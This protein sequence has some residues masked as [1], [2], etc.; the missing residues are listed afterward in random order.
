MACSI[1]SLALSGAISAQLEESLLTPV[2]APAVH[3]N[4]VLIAPA[5]LNGLLVSAT[6]ADH[7]YLMVDFLLD[8]AAS[9][10]IF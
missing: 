5:A 2:G 1:G 8:I 3:D 6:I 7:S 4:P 10:V 9:E